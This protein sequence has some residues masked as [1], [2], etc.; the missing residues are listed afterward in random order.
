MNPVFGFSEIV[1]FSWSSCSRIL[2]DLAIKVNWNDKNE[3]IDDND[4]KPFKNNKFKKQNQKTL[5]SNFKNSNST[6]SEGILSHFNLKALNKLD[7]F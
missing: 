4:L 7:L 5:D 1:R 3:D 6:N 2:E